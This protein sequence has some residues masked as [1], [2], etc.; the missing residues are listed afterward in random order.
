MSITRGIAVG[1]AAPVKVA[2]PERLIPLREAV[3]ALY[4]Q[5]YVLERRQENN[6]G[7]ISELALQEATM[8]PITLLTRCGCER[9]VMVEARYGRPVSQFYRTPMQTSLSSVGLS[10]MRFEMEQI[11]TTVREFR[12]KHQVHDG[13][14]FM[15]RFVF[16]EV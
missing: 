6:W 15:T 5:G 4:D 14:K 10:P 2:E 16:E 1:P 7:W 13:V 12:F 11:T 9:I 8:V 3:R